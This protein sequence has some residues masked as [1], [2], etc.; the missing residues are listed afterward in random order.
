MTR[1]RRTSKSLGPPDV[2]RRVSFSEENESVTLRPARTRILT[3][4][5]WERSAQTQ[6]VV[7]H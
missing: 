5:L 6:S 2:G 1:G 7:R 3:R 4:G